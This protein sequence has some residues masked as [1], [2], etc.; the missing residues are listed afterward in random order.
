MLTLEV[1][2]SRDKVPIRNGYRHVGQR[3]RIR[4]NGGVEH[5]LVSAP[6]HPRRPHMLIRASLADGPCEAPLAADAIARCTQLRRRPSLWTSTSRRCS[7]CAMPG[8]LASDH[9][10]AR[11]CKSKQHIPSSAQQSLIIMYV[12]VL[13]V[14]VARCINASADSAAEPD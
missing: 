3:A 12:N 5:E 13:C 11:P 4:V 7:R 8:S 2:A 6:L 1:E 10:I 14:R 9:P